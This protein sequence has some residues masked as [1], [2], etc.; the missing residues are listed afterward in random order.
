MLPLGEL[1][2]FVWALPIVLIV[3]LVGCIAVS[4]LLGTN[5]REIDSDIGQ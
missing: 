3:L 1:L 2:V 4:E 5:R